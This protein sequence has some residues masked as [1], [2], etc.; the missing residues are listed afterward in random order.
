MEELWRSQKEALCVA[1][2][3]RRKE[4]VHKT[5]PMGDE[6]DVV[7][8]GSYW[9]DETGVRSAG[10]EQTWPATRLADIFDLQLHLSP[11]QYGVGEQLGNRLI[12]RRARVETV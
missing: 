3:M 9:Q 10:R 12:V 11:W 2:R 1:C 6:D 7:L 8:D 5:D 4:A